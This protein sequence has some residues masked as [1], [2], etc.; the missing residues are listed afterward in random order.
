MSF[1]FKTL[2]E[3]ARNLSAA[4][5]ALSLLIK[6]AQLAFPKASG[7]LKADFVV[8]S[9]IEIEPV[10]SAH[11]RLLRSSITSLVSAHKSSK[12]GWIEENA[13]N[14]EPPPKE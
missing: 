13:G 3:Q 1:D 2:Q 12:T 14:G 5:P 4:L 6:A 9:I 7:L 10:F 8:N 11:E